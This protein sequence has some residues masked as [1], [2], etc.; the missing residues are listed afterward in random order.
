MAALT[1][2]I[3]WELNQDPQC[4]LGVSADLFSG[5]STIQRSYQPSP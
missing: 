2:V 5:V 4:I 1:S 3:I